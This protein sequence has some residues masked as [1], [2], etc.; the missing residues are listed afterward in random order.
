VSQKVK[1]SRQ[2]TFFWLALIG[3]LVAFFV[4][5]L[6]YVGE[7][8]W[9]YD[10]GV[11]T[12]AA[13]LVRSGYSRYSEVS[14]LHPPLFVSSF[15]LAF[16]LFG[17]SLA[18]ARTLVLVYSLIG[19]LSVALVARKLAGDWAGLAAAT[20]LSFA[21]GFFLYSWMALADGP[22]VSLAVLSLLLALHYW[23]SGKRGELI[24]AGLALWASFM[25]KLLTLFVIPLLALLVVF[26]YIGPAALEQSTN[27]REWWRALGT[28]LG[29]L[30]ASL[31]L[32]TLLILL[33]YDLPSLYEQVIATLWDMRRVYP[34]DVAQNWRKVFGLLGENWSLSILALYGG[35]LLL[36][37]RFRP[38]LPVGLW[39]ALALL[40]LTNNAPL[41]P[42]HLVVLFP[43]LAILG[44]VAVGETLHQVRATFK[45]SRWGA[46]VKS[47]AGLALMALYLVSLPGLIATNDQQLSPQERAKYQDVTHFLSK[48]TQPSDLIITDNQWIVFAADRE[49]PPPLSDTG[50]GRLKSG[51]LTAEE[52]V[53]LTVAYQPQAILVWG[54]RFVNNVPSYVEW[55][56]S[57]YQVARFY[58]RKRAVYMP[59]A[60]PPL[61]EYTFGGQIL[62][63]GYDPD[64]VKLQD[65]G[66]LTI[67]LYW[68]ALRPVEGDY[69]IYLKLISGAYHV[70]GEQDARP[71]WD[72]FPTNE[73][74]V[75]QI[76]FDPR[77]IP[78][79]PG[80]PPGS[81][82][83]AVSLYDPYRGQA[84][85]LDSGGE[86]L[87]EP[88]EIPR[89]EP[90]AL[91]SLDI[92]HSQEA[93]LGDKVRLLGYNMESGFR[94]GD[95]IHLTL[96]WQC[97]EEMDRD[98]TV[99]THLIDEQGIIWG[100][101]DN[102]P[103]DGFYPTSQW[104][105][106]EVVRDQYDILISSEAPPG[107]YQIEVGMYLAETGERLSVFEGEQEAGNR[108]LLASEIRVE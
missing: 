47:L 88:I 36:L 38:A 25:M 105:M 99:F 77:E 6:G 4:W 65:D 97:L 82:Q 45:P 63:L 20:L 58:G 48:A 16:T 94:P 54:G 27:R 35:L 55:V 107:E 103:V 22:A 39:L 15:A 68:R 60:S 69:R 108:V 83:L 86:L 90:P 95:G 24:A 1:I 64:S 59:P 18:V 29:L 57:N 34:L 5:E 50:N 14:S 23:E 31:L 28:D 84:L 98:Y 62:F 8:R 76:V 49:T 17:N 13:R 51:H 72:G 12:M 43:P 93:I 30:A 44:G 19:R 3:I 87:L 66:T 106:G 42:Q 101:K 53:D 100:Q 70:W 102:P 7:P 75:D 2:D 92:E 85:E 81:Y 71:F 104:E 52:L 32:P 79:L 78:V 89:R 46:E 9:D 67:S 73:W 37:R 80:T 26:R 11:H 33:I 74:E 10:E 41:R 21:P 61:P 91:T 40:A 56:E 96:F